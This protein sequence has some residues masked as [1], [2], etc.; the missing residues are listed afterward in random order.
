MS[1]TDLKRG[2]GLFE[3][4]IIGVGVIIGAGIYV[5]IGKA[6][7]MTGP[8]VWIS[9]VIAAILAALT[10]LSYAELS[11]MFPKDSSE[12]LYVKKAFKWES[13]AFLTG[14]ICIITGAIAAA[15][16][17][18]GFAGYFNYVF[19]TPI[20]FT[21]LFVIVLLSTINFMGIRKSA[22]FTAP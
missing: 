4:T 5:L 10:G 7:G 16:V 15:A 3:T 12:Y 20:I 22:N 21:A 13:L 14:W 9:F 8:S 1:N 6:T 2:L 11:S 18:L 19:N 17:S